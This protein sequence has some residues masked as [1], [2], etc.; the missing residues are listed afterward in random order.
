MIGFDDADYERD[1]PREPAN[2]QTGIMCNGQWHDCVITNISAS[3]AKLSLSL[4]ISR[5]KD[6][7]IKLGEFGQFNATVA[8]C[9]GGEIG[10]RFDH[11]PLEMTRVLIAM[12]S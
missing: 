9:S 12:A 8:W 10:V 7:T 11:D 4:N 5:G 3:G 2:T 1:Y 6:V